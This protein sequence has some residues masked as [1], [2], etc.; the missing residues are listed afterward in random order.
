MLTINRSSDGLFESKKKMDNFSITHKVL[1]EILFTKDRPWEV[2]LQERFA[3]LNEEQLSQVI[4][5]VKRRFEP[6]FLK[7]L[8][9]INH[10]NYEK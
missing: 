1:C 10:R 8:T 5:Q 3:Y 7:R 6:H 2:C 9:E 4:Q